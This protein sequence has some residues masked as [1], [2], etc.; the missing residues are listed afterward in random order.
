LDILVVEAATDETL[1]IEDRVGGVHG[2]LV[3]GGIADET[4]RVGEGDI[5]GGGAVTLVVG[6]DL[7]TIVL[8]DG[9]ARVGGSQIN[10]DS[11]KETMGDDDVIREGWSSSCHSLVFESDREGGFGSRQ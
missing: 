5:G 1:G 2:D 7:D 6:D 11:Y 9:D 10:T 3:L 4:L 8:P